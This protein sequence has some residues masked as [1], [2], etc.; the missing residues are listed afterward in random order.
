MQLADYTAGGESHPAP[1]NFFRDGLY[2]IEDACVK[3][4]KRGLRTVVQQ[5]FV[6]VMIRLIKW[7]TV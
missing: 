1:K 5:P 3:I 6:C 4:K 7:K 2:Y